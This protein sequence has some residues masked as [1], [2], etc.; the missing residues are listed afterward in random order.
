M[1]SH[2]TVGLI[3]NKEHVFNSD[4]IISRCDFKCSFSPSG[5]SN[6]YIHLERFI[7]SGKGCALPKYRNIFI[8]RWDNWDEQSR[9]YKNVLKI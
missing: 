5:G 2:G 3:Q 4:N 1:P 7:F 6:L 8:Y 9:F